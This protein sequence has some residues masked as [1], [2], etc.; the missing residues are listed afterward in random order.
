M[1]NYLSVIC[2]LLQILGLF[3]IMGMPLFPKWF[4][5]FIGILLGVCG[6]AAVVKVFLPLEFHQSLLGIAAAFCGGG[7]MFMGYFKWRGEMF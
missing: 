6:F 3:L 7:I 4:P 2:S 5:R 1:L